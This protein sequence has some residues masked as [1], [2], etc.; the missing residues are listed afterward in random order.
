MFSIKDILRAKRTCTLVC[1]KLLI[2]QR[3]TKYPPLPQHILQT[4]LLRVKIFFYS[5]RE[6]RAE[7]EVRRDVVKAK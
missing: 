1:V 4:G 7:E 2:V 5:C 6:R 3:V